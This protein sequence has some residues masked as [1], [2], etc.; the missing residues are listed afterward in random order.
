MAMGKYKHL[1][2]SER[3]KIMVMLWE[4]K[5]LG[6]ISK[7]LGRSKSTISREL[8]NNSSPEYKKY[9]S[10]RA[11]QRAVQKRENA[12]KRQRLKDVRIVSYVRAKLKEGW[13]PEQ[14][15]G[16]ISID[17]PG[18]SISHEAI[19]QYIYYPKTEGHRELISCLRRAHRKRK[20]K[21]IGRREKK[22][23]IPNRISIELRPPSVEKRR[24]YGHWEGDSLV[25]RK[26]KVALNS[27]VERKSRLLFLTKLERK[28]AKATRDAV[29]N[30]L[31]ILP[32]QARITLTLDNGTENTK[33]QE[34]TSAIG[35]NCF[36]A[37]PY[38]S[39]ERGTNENI[40]GLVRWYLPKG[41]DFRNISNDEIARIESLINNRPRK[42][43]GFKTPL[44]VAYPFVAL[45]C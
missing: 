1:S 22:S 40:N 3:D 8:T 43:L 35:I 13:S 42:C 24:Q 36:F 6:A 33:H 29:V 12:S 4:K 20:N 44:E 25:S 37:H 9:L 39:W 41:T 28:T 7:A 17:H 45:R 23:M 26:S 2:L 18:L 27:L 16:R 5:S 10:H 19:Y 32:P 21:H 11:H 38:A 34:I 15:S 31:E 14:V 30:R